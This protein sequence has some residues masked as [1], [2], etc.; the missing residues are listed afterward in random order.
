MSAEARLFLSLSGHT[1]SENGKSREHSLQPRFEPRHPRIKI[2]TTTYPLPW[3]EARCQ[4]RGQIILRLPLDLVANVINIPTAWRSYIPHHLVGKKFGNL[5]QAAVNSRHAVTSFLGVFG[6]ELRFRAEDAATFRKFPS[7]G[8][9]LFSARELLRIT[10]TIVGCKTQI[11]E[12]ERHR[13]RDTLY[14]PQE[15]GEPP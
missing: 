6:R 13:E 4:G 7:H 14:M 11:S 3:S 1:S 8:Q 2:S 15:G 5:V 10:Y 9:A 12:R